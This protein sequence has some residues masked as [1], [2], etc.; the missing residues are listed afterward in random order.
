MLRGISVSV[1]ILLSSNL[2]KYPPFK[3]YVTP[4]KENCYKR[5][6]KI[7]CKFRKNIYQ[8]INQNLKTIYQINLSKPSIKTI[9][10]NYLPKLS[11]KTIFQNYLPKLCT[12]TI[13]Q[14]YLSKLSIKTIYLN[15][16]SKL[17][18]KAIY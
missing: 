1:I 11:T 17:S 18:I 15:Y 2:Q 10:Q 16:L 14:K 3:K 4:K 5:F 8:T 7:E 6:S 13:N 12:K 9:Y